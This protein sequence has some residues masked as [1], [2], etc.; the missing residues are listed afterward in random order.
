MVSRCVESSCS[1]PD[2]ASPAR[3]SD[4]SAGSLRALGRQSLESAG[5]AVG[6]DALVSGRGAHDGDVGRRGLEILGGLERLVQAVAEQRD[7]CGE[8]ARGLVDRRE[9][10]RLQGALAGERLVAQRERDGAE[11]HGRAR[12]VGHG[13]PPLDL[14]RRVVPGVLVEGSKRCDRVGHEAQ[15]RRE[16]LGALG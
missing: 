11:P 9:L 2:S 4:D 15:T 3:S 13:E 12:N 8:R 7:A 1:A 14:G 10:Q 6:V 5:D 16:L